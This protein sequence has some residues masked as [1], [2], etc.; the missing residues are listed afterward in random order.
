MQRDDL[1][2]LFYRNGHLLALVILVIV[3]AGVSALNSLPR[4]EDPRITTRNA[5]I[6]TSFPGASAERVEALVTKKLEEELR[7][8]EEIKDIDSTSRANVSVIGVELLDRI[9]ASN[10]EQA[11]SR[12]RDKLADAEADLPPGAGKPVFDDQ[13]GASAFSLVVAL[14]TRTNDSNGLGMLSRLAEE[15]ADRFRNLPGAERVRVYGDTGEEITITLDRGELAAQGLSSAAV[16]ALVAAADPKSAAGALR[17]ND[18]DLFLEVGGELDSVARIRNLVIR[19]GEPGRALRLGDIASVER[20]WRLPPESYG[21]VNGERVVFVAAAASANVRVD[22]WQAQAEQVLAAFEQGL[23]DGIRVETVF[24]QSDYTNQR[25]MSLGGNLLLGALVVMLVV[26]FGLGWR[27][28]LIVGAALPLSAFATLFGLTFFGQQI[29]QM[30]IFGMIIAIGLLIDNAIVVTDEIQRRRKAGASGKE[31]VGRAVSHLFAPLLASTVTTI[32]GFMPVFLLPGNV[33][34]FVGPIAIAVV[35]A[36]AASFVI[37]MTVIAAL[38]G[39]FIPGGGNP[40][41]TGSNS[42][43]SESIR[44]DSA[45]SDAADRDSSQRGWWHQGIQ[46]PT[47]NRFCHSLLTHALN[48]PLA[49]IAAAFVLPVAGFIAA[50]TLSLQFF[51]PAERDQFE[52]ELRL[53]DEASLQRTR[54]TAMAIERVVTGFDGVEQISW[55]VGG[56]HPQFYY[57]RIMDEDGNA[58][59]AHAMVQV[60]SAERA[61][62]L[63]PVLQDVVDR[64][65]PEAQVIV[66]PFAQGPPVDAPVGFRIAGPSLSVLDERGAELRRIMHEVPGISHTR[67][68]ISS[69]AKLTYRADQQHSELTGLSL[70]AIAEQLQGNLEGFTGG[71]VREDLEELPV[72]IRYDN[73]VRETLA[74]IASMPLLA[75]GGAGWVPADALGPMRLEP[76]SASITRR[77]GERVNVIHA[78]V[79]PG[80]LPIE[81]AAEV[82]ARLDDEGFTLPPGYSLQM[83]GDSDAQRDAVGAL[84]TYL[85][86]LIMLMVTALVLS[87]RSAGAAAVIGLVALLSAGLGMLSLWLS[88]YN[89]GFN[90]L[91][92]S[93]GLI[94]VAING[95]IVVLAALRADPAAADGDTDAIVRIT[96]REAR[97]VLAT[98][99]TTIGGFLPLLVFVGGNFWP[100]LAVVIAGGVGFSVVLSLLFTPA[101]FKLM[102]TRRKAVARMPARAGFA[103]LLAAVGLGG[104]AV[105]PDYVAPDPAPD[106]AWHEI[107]AA[108]QIGEGVGEGVSEGISNGAAKAIGTATDKESDNASGPPRGWWRAFDDPLIESYVEAA[109]DSNHDVAIAAARLDEARALRR[110]ARSLLLPGIDAQ[111]GYTDF[112]LSEESPTLAAGGPAAS[113][114]DSLYEAGFDAA[115]ELD[116]FG[117]NR[118]RVEASSARLDATAAELDAV[119]LSII[120]EVVRTVAELRGAQ[121]RL[122]VATDNRALQRETLTLVEG[123]VASGLSPELDVLTAS[124]QLATTRSTVPQ[125]EAAIR[126]AAYRLATL[127]GRDIVDVATEVATPGPIP[128]QAG[129][130]TAGLRSDVLRR[131]P[132]VQAA[133]RALAAATADIGVAVADLFPRLQLSGQYGWQALAVD[134]IGDSRT[135]NS[136]LVG[137][138]RL[139]LYSGGRRKAE[140]EAARA[141]H[142][143]S[144]AA[145]EQTVLLALEESE[146]ALARYARAAASRRHLD[147]AARASAEA[148][149]IARRLYESGLTDFLSVLDADRRRL[150]AEDAL[151]ERATEEVVNLVAVYKALGVS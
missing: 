13:R 3:L 21:Y 93:A 144:I 17:G 103:S 19:Q 87:F 28:A 10:N 133:E 88:G 92:G 68:S 27:A 137:I 56:S 7:E 5:L 12:V 108:G 35:L 76:E 110:Q 149:V 30:T 38:S 100:P 39:R 44:L 128:S 111:T 114:S 72:R 145:Y 136:A 2:N 151:A 98:T 14:G 67:T 124:A 96:M 42:A 61:A 91:I 86:V 53:P 51:P 71:S 18:R 115:W 77:N 140:I 90:P 101:V 83:E 135:E 22:R 116:V 1:S 29:H 70:D 143:V 118:R 105:G 146:G 32:L 125:L 142:R 52:I 127:T 113:R 69:R 109:L 138:L 106:S 59:Y 16:A 85:P 54:V 26:L 58:A 82:L 122:R 63:V 97:H 126:T 141:R 94:G 24:R 150:E 11:F 147:T 84:T 123:R 80:V 102:S 49:A 66:A 74:D 75:G 4:I 129:T 65:F 78:W 134:G 60:D 46:L 57:N 148:A 120:A 117:G 48:R 6:L 64:Q 37:S 99:A 130:V 34:D 36:L 81:A 50:G 131:R 119:R 62:E 132:D 20:H 79:Q 43:D 47:F 104:C 45:E 40:D 139:P 25:L 41:S 33:G 55:L 8:V 95:A 112:R 9:D 121:T 15:L 89:L 23:D 107:E 73:Q 31:A